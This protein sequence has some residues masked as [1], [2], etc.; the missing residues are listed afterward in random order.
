MTGS[1]SATPVER[2]AVEAP[3]GACAD[4]R[5]DVV[6]GVADGARG[7]QR[8]ELVGRVG[9]HESRDRFDGGHAGADEDGGDDEQSGAALG[10]L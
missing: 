6:A 5:G 2:G 4:L 1:R 10:A 3:S 8:A 7:G 9:V